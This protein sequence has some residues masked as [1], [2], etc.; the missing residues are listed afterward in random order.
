MGPTFEQFMM[1][2][3]FWVPWAQV[4]AAL[5]A[6]MPAAP[7]RIVVYDGACRTC[8]RTVAVLRR[9][10]IFARLE[11]ADLNVQWAALAAAYPDLDE[12]ACVEDVHVV[13][14]DPRTAAVAIES[15]FDGYRSIARL[16]PL[17]WPLLPLLYVPGARAVGRRIYRATMPHG[18]STRPATA[19]APQLS[20]ADRAA[21]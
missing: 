1:C 20:R 8:A 4:G 14:V 13:A 11:Y 12:A 5:R 19:A 7:L 2:Y 18:F 21:R 16:L 6:R 10:D 9:L 3:V 15:G 17:A